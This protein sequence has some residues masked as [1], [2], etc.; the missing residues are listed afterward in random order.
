MNTYTLCQSCAAVVDLRAEKAL[1][2][3]QAL[4]WSDGSG[5]WICTTGDGHVPA[6][7]DSDVVV[8]AANALAYARLAVNT[9]LYPDATSDADFAL[10]DRVG[11][12]VCDT[13]SNLLE[14]E[15]TG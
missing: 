14:A 6:E 15:V 10:L 2:G 3:D 1:D 4:V 7:A 12:A 8:S 13:L 5:S 11:G 9:L